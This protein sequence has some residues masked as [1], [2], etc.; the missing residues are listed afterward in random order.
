MFVCV[1]VGVGVGVCV[2]EVG[3]GMGILPGRRDW[4]RK[5]RHGSKCHPCGIWPRICRQPEATIEQR[6]SQMASL[7]MALLR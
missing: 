2:C 6:K 3:H 4:S 1:G 5:S 7:D